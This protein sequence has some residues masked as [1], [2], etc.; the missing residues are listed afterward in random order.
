[1]TTSPKGFR[2]SFSKPAT[3]QSSTEPQDKSQ[4]WLNIGYNVELDAVDEDGRVSEESRFISLNY[5]IPVDRIEAVSTKSSNPNWAMEQQARN[6]LLDQLL[7]HAGEMKPGE[8]QVID[9]Q[10]QLRRIKNE[11]EILVPTSDNPFSRKVF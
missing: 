2:P 1:M 8:T 11:S 4:F 3:K 10:I 7:A 9:L 5:G 6:D